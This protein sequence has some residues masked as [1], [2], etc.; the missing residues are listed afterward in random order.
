MDRIG[1]YQ[2]RVVL[3]DYVPLLFFT[4]PSPSLTQKDLPKGYARPMVCSSSIII[5]SVDWDSALVSW[6]YIPAAISHMAH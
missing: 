4:C 1:L 2:H 6:R 5:R 3:Q